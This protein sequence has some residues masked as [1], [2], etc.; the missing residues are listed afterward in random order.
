MGRLGREAH[1]WC[2]TAVTVHM[3]HNPIH[4]FFHIL[5]GLEPSAQLSSLFRPDATLHISKVKAVLSGE[6]IDEWAARMQATWR[7]AATLHSEGNIVLDHVEPNVII[8]HST[9][10]AVIDGAI[11]AYGTHADVLEAVVNDEYGGVEWKFRRRVVRH[12]FS[13]A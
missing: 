8:N 7:G 5:D 11:T 9:W 12:L 2:S 3:V 4:R 10:T 13:A 6:E 1:R